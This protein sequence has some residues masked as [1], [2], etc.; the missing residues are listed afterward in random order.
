M[1]KVHVYE[2]TLPIFYTGTCAELDYAGNLEKKN[3]YPLI[4][5]VDAVI[6]D[7]THKQ[8]GLRFYGFLEESIEK[9]NPQLK[10]DIVLSILSKMKE[11][12]WNLSGIKVIK[13]WEPNVIH[14]YITGGLGGNKDILV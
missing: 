5:V 2:N 7:G 10:E 12:K 8:L 1:C 13:D 3:R 6:D 14:T 4:H 9:E 11:D